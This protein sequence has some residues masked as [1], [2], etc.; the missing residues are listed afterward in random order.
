MKASKTHIVSV[1]EGFDFLSFNLKRVQTNNQKQST[2]LKTQPTKKNIISFLSRIREVIE[3]YRKHGKMDELISKI[4][5]MLRGWAEYFR[6]SS[7]S[8]DAFEHIRNY[9]WNKMWTTLKKKH[10]KKGQKWLKQHSIFPNSTHKWSLSGT[11][12]I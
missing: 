1:H 11:C 2:V 7:H 12:S 8:R 5:P 3:R 4:N 9:L 10:R 6:I